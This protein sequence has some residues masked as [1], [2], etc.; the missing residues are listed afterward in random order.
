MEGLFG[1]DLKGVCGGLGDFEPDLNLPSPGVLGELSGDSEGKE[2]RD[3]A[4]LGV[5]RDCFLDL[6]RTVPGLWDRVEVCD[7]ALSSLPLPDSGMAS[8]LDFGTFL[9]K[10]LRHYTIVFVRSDDAPL[11]DTVI[12]APTSLFT[13]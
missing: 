1:L 3:L 7:E 8:S 2:T 9:A 12:S 5:T 10:V 13:S 4:E 11:E 6:V